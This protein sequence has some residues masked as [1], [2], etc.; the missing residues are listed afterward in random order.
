MQCYAKLLLKG[1]QSFFL[2]LSGDKKKKKKFTKVSFFCL[3]A[4]FFF[5]YIRLYIK[6]LILQAKEKKEVE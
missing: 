3:S 1:K 2:F 5:S 4:S 6:R